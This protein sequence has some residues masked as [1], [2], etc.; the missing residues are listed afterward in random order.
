MS[1]KV[2]EFIKKEDI[3]V[4]FIE[5]D[6]KVRT[7]GEAKGA[8]GVSESQIAKAIVFK[9]R[10]GRFRMVICSGDRKIDVSKVESVAGVD[11]LKLAKPSEIREKLGFEVGGIP[12][13]GFDIE[14]DV[15]LDSDLLK[16]GHVFPSGGSDDSL[17]KIDPY[18]LKNIPEPELLTLVHDFERAFWLLEEGRESW[19]HG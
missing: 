11:E 13:F 14:V 6:T 9:D 1:R 4:E 7:V 3:E 16:Y 10:S 15:Y 19:T 5:L 18:E 2:K 12:P 17:M 8:L